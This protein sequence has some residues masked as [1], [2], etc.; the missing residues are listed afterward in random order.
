[1]TAP[2]APVQVAPK[3]GWR[4]T[5][6]WTTIFTNVVA[7]ILLVWPGHDF[8]SFVQI[9]AVGAAGVAN[10]FYAHSRGL[11]KATH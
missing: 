10:A 4:S 1:M 2:V 6:F 7:V 9:A 8:S 11:V 5:E 3:T